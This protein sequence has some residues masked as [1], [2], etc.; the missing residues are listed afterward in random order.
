MNGIANVMLNLDQVNWSNPIKIQSRQDTMIDLYKEVTGRRSL[1]DGKSYWSMAGQCYSEK[2]GGYIVG[3]EYDQI[4]KSGLVKPKQFNGVEFNK[5]IYE[6]NRKIEKA[7]WHNGYFADVVAEN[8][9]SNPGIVRHDDTTLP[10]TCV[11]DFVELF[12]SLEDIDDILVTFTMALR[13]RGHEATINDLAKTLSNHP[14]FLDTFYDGGWSYSKNCYVYTS[15]VAGT[16]MATV[17][18]WK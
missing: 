12:Y 1:P 3:S 15:N 6:A 8:L 4:I 16:E 5:D 14:W 17:Y 13:T 2:D 18:F 10:Q 7:N 11:N 9:D